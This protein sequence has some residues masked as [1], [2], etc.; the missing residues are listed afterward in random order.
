MILVFNKLQLQNINVLSYIPY[1]D[2]VLENV[3]IKC[4]CV[5]VCVNC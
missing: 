1:V 5:C 2:C 4:V 3:Y